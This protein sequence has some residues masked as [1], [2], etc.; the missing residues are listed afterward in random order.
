MEQYLW[1]L[2]VGL[3]MV[4]WESI[5]LVL[6]GLYLL[7]GIFLAYKWHRQAVYDWP[8]YGKTTWLE[9]FLVNFFVVLLW[10]IAAITRST[11]C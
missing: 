9:V 3:L 8:N 7:I 5:W 6:V 10:P 2:G 4:A 1:L 11:G